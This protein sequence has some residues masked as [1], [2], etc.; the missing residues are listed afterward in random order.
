M[1][2]ASHNGRPQQIP[3]HQLP[4]ANEARPHSFEEHSGLSDQKVKDSKGQRTLKGKRTV[5][6]KG[7]KG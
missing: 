7:P 3:L 2:C 6:A 5:R 1:N 4:F